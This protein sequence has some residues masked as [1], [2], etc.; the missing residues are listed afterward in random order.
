MAVIERKVQ[1]EISFACEGGPFFK[2][3]ETFEDD[4][5]IWIVLNCPNTDNLISLNQKLFKV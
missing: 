2:F 3:L 1:N 4:E 5:A